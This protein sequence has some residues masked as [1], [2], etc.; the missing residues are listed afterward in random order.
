MAGVSISI[1]VD[2]QRLQRALDRASGIE[3][4]QEVVGG[5]AED[6]MRERI[7]DLKTSPDGVPWKPWS[8]SYAGSKHGRTASHAPHPDQLE[9][10]GGHS[11]LQLDGDL[12]DNMT[13]EKAPGNAVEVGTDRVYAPFVNAAREFAGLSSE[14]ERDI[15]DEITDWLDRQMA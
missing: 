11:L 4:L 9:R 3:E 14:N 10:S 2:D 12:L 7:Q 15:E 8:K 13:W 6:Q 5:A 1:S